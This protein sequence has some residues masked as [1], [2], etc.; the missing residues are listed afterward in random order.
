MMRATVRQLES[1]LAQRAHT[2]TFSDAELQGLP[3]PVR[4]HLAAVIAPGTPLA[5]SA[6][7]EMRGQIKIGRWVPFRA[8]EVLTPRRGFVWT[9]RAAGL[10]TGYDHYANGHGGMD[11]KL[12][13]LVRVSHADGPDV[14]RAAA[15]RAGAEAIWLP[16]ALLPR[17]GVT[18]TATDDTNISARFD[19]DDHP[20]EVHYRINE[21][22]YVTSLAFERWHDAD[23]IGIW[24]S[25]PCGGDV[26]A[27]RSLDGVT[28]PSA[29]TF[30]W[31]YGTDRWTDG[32]FFR[33]E[34][35]ALA[36][37]R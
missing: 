11:W 24:G 19:V 29:G 1:A 25:H 2:D 31:F 26:A 18:W 32:Q 23:G 8:H 6:R 9:A 36:L 16:T 34:I 33:Y 35:T 30:G 22:G 37:E 3:D 14:S 15:E 27:H 21:Q 28:I 12:A 4:R 17:F 5:Q 20:L 13:G 10:V 7:I